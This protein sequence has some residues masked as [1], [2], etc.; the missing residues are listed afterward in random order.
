MGADRF[1]QCRRV[2]SVG[3]GKP[4]SRVE[5]LQQPKR[6]AKTAPG[7]REIS[8]SSQQSAEIKVREHKVAIQVERVPRA[9]TRLR[10][11]APA[12]VRARRNRIGIADSTAPRQAV[13]GIAQTHLPAHRA[14]SGCRPGLA[15]TARSF[16]IGLIPFVRSAAYAVHSFWAALAAAVDASMRVVCEAEQRSEGVV[17]PGFW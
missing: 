3:A 1:G 14:A 7:A 4:C 13:L 10:G 2:R 17:E 5:H 16:A 8:F 12:G 15:C 9:P 6:V 11:S